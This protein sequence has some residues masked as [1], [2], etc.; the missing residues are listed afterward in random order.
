[1]KTRSFIAS[2]LVSA[3]AITGF[4]APRAQALSEDDLAKLIFGAATIAIIAKVIDD[5]NDR[6]KAKRSH[7]P[8]TAHNPKPHKPPVINPHR[9]NLVLPAHCKRE[10]ITPRGNNVRGF[11]QRCLERA[12]YSTRHLPRDCRFS[13][14]TRRGIGTVYGARCLRQS[15]YRVSGR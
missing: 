12:N 1:M 9:R 2:V 15:G 8:Q 3:M 5:Q 6:K 14:N 13:V 10:F 4:S 7:P 11:R